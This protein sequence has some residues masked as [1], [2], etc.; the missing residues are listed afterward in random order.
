MKKLEAMRSIAAI[1]SIAL[2]ALAAILLT[3]TM[4]VSCGDGAGGGGNNPGNDPGGGLS[5]WEKYKN[6]IQK[7]LPTEEMVTSV[8]LEFTNFLDT[9]TDPSTGYYGYGYFKSGSKIIF[10]LHYMDYDAAKADALRITTGQWIDVVPFNYQSW[11]TLCKYAG[12][13]YEPGV[14]YGYGCTFSYYDKDFESSS[15]LTFPGDAGYLNVGFMYGYPVI[16]F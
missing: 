3:G 14:D 10:S 7:G 9:F 4:L 15:K 6:N 12:T 2:I 5:E 13:I 16:E 8:H 11:N 1:H